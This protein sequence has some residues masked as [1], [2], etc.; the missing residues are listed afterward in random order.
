M[1]V[2]PD[3]RIDMKPAYILRSRIHPSAPAHFQR[4]DL[5]DVT[6]LYV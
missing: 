2:R 6:K 3:E 1:L 4:P 5:W